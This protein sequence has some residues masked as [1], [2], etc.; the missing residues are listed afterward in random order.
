MATLASSPPTLDQMAAQRWLQR[1]P[2]ASPWLHEEVGQ[3]M[4]QRLDWIKLKPSHWLDWAPV[5]GGLQAHRAVAQALAA[6]QSLIWEPVERHRTEALRALRPPWWS[7]ARR[8]R[9][10]D[11]MLEQQPPVGA[12]QMLWSNM[13]L[14]QHPEPRQ[15]IAQWHNA[16]QPDGYL[17]FSC[18]GPD[19][20]HELTALYQR[21]GWG[22]CAAQFTDMH[23]WGDMLVEA[24]F[25]EP[26][27]DMERIRLTYSH[28]A[29]MRGDLR[30][31]GRNT[32]ASR[33]RDVHGKYWL[34][35]WD[36]AVQQLAAPSDGGRLALTFEIIYGHA[37][38]PHPRMKV[39]EFSAVSLQEMRAMLKKGGPN[40][41]AAAGQGP[42]VE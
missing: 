16:L 37:V 26:I 5:R 29:A 20:L 1:A 7:L 18:L 32:H 39:S 25:A 42:R 17:M 21:L 11:Q 15:L 27:M 22:P 41:S 28:G 13:L 35:Q 24:G 40:K 6:S 3:R 30:V 14:H 2:A 8:W 38:K 9:G 23:D 4:A 36:A 19:T 34:A 12:A 33:D 31:L 10:R